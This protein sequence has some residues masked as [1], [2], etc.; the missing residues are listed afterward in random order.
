MLKKQG[1]LAASKEGLKALAVL[2]GEAHTEMT[3]I[4]DATDW[5]A[6]AEVMSFIELMLQV[7]L[8]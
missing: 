5:K 2:F 3:P 4:F 7:C 8:P 1:E 6:E